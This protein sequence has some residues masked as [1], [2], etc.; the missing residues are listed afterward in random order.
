MSLP[1]QLFLTAPTA[2][3]K[4][5]L[6][7]SNTTTVLLDFLTNRVMND[8]AKKLRKEADL[9][10]MDFRMLVMLTQEPGCT[11]AHASKTIGIDKGA[12]SRSLSRLESIDAIRAE[13]HTSDPRRR[14]WF[15]TK[16]GE[17]LHEQLLPSSLEHLGQ[18]LEGFTCDEVLQLN[19]FLRRIIRNAGNP[20]E[21]L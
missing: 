11:V 20:P 2:P 19:E 16:K 7:F 13:L 21:T 6:D 10:V 5:T 9:S 14:S 17:K 1:E 8:G 18:L 4:Q 3:K 15:L 12:I